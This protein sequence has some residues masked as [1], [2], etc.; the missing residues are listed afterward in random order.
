MP[1][2][3]LPHHR[4]LQPLNQIGRENHPVHFHPTRIDPLLLA[5]PRH[6]AT[7][8]PSRAFTRQIPRV[9]H[10]DALPIHLPHHIHDQH[11]QSHAITAHQDARIRAQIP[12]QL[13]GPAASC[14]QRKGVH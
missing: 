13:L 3:R 4:R 2:L 1:E 11:S 10:P 9:H 12:T 5:L 7:N 8:L 6:D 14:Q